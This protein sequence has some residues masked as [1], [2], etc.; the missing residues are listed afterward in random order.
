MIED[1][2]RRIYRNISGERAWGYMSEIY[3]RDRWS[4]F[5]GYRKSAEF[6]ADMLWLFDTEESETVRFPADGETRF[7]DWMMPLSWEPLE[8]QLEI[9]A[10]TNER[11]IFKLKGNPNRLVM[12]SAPTR[13]EGD[14]G[15]LIPLERG[16]PDELERM[17]VRGCV[18]FTPSNPAS[19]K[20][21]AARMGALG[22][23]S[24]LLKAKG[25]H[26]AIQWVNTWSD[27]PG[28]WAMH[29][30]DSRIWGIMLSPKEGEQLRRLARRYE[31]RAR[32]IVSSKLY[33]GELAYAT[34]RIIGRESPDEEILLTAHINEQGANDNASGAAALIE[35]ARVLN[36]MIRSGQLPPPARSI[37]FLMMPESY[38]MMAFTVRNLE[39]L[40]R[41]PAA[42]NVDGGAGDYDST[43]SNLTVYLDPLCCRSPVDGAVAWIARIFY[44]EIVRRPDKLKFH[45]YTLAGDNF[46]CEPLI[47]VPNPWFEMG[48][49][50]EYWHNSE[51]TPD[52]VDPRS[53]KDL[54]SLTAGAAYIL[55]SFDRG[56]IE[57]LCGEGLK[58]LPEDLRSF[59]RMKVPP[60]EPGSGPRRLLVGALTLDGIPPDRWRVVKGSPRW[61]GPYLAAWWWADG[62]RSLK[63]IEEML[64]LEFGSA[65]EDLD[66]FFDFLGEMHLLQQPAISPPPKATHNTV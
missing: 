11:L 32:A 29:K 41:S 22:I 31:L 14:E 63:L 19:I 49:G 35:T 55:A 6:C 2:L 64:R 36:E 51:D 53:L 1:L 66:E 54:A 48:D 44:D 23:V 45:R 58:V 38:G 62:N 21:M 39:R 12:W 4:S 28:G 43:D 65:P 26:D 34:G 5:D 20:P 57:R 40:R 37:R 30:G 42:I 7:G 24:D 18:L 17:E 33:E 56:E 46:L 16:T 47:G 50:G 9:I 10:P 59:L 8:A 15:K 25:L 61:W 13:P 52:K 60:G 27:S 3:S